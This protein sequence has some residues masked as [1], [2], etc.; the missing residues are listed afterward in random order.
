M[1][2][3][4]EPSLAEQKDELIVIEVYCVSPFYNFKVFKD[5]LPP[6]YS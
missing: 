1:S 4:A 2:S 5:S 6:E 3:D